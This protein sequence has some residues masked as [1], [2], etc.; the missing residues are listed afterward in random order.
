MTCQ[1]W[2]PDK[3]GLT[4]KKKW[5][6]PDLVT[7]GIHCGLRIKAEALTLKWDSVDLKRGLVT[8]EAAYAKNGRTRSIP[9]NPTM[10]GALKALKAT[11]TGEYVFVNEEGNPYKSVGSIFKRAC[12]RY[13]RSLL[14]RDLNPSAVEG[15]KGV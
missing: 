4:P 5:P 14:E 13:V 6:R 9:L 8:V 7:V 11:V 1:A 3:L 2:R 12:R 10:L 15:K